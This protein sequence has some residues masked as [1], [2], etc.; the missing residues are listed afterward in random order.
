[1]HYSAF[2]ERWII[3]LLIGIVD[4]LL[5]FFPRQRRCKRVPMEVNFSI[6]F[7]PE[8]CGVEL[9][10]SLDNQNIKERQH[11]IDFFFVRKLQVCMEVV[12]CR[13]NTSQGTIFNQTN[14]IIYVT[15]PKSNF[16]NTGN[17]SPR[18]NKC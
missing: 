3:K 10:I 18:W 16:W 12:K 17:R 8:N 15:E 7:F 13:Q 1:M 14:S 9:F 2:F 6:C 11:A 4:I 5:W